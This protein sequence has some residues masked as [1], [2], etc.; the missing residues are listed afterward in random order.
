MGSKPGKSSA[1]K[2]TAFLRKGLLAPQIKARHAVREYRQKVLGRKVQRN[3]GG[4]NPKPVLEA[5]ESDED[6]PPKKAESDS[7]DDD[8]DVDAVMGAEGLEEVSNSSFG[9]ILMWSRP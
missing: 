9:A 3:K 8:E 1:K 2:T 7:E 5:E 6:A 4:K